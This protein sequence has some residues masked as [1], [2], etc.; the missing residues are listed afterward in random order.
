MALR[1]L[2][3]ILPEGDL[4]KL[5]GVFRTDS[6]RGGPWRY[7]IEGGRKIVRVLI[8]AEESARLV[9]AIEQRCAGTAGSAS[10]T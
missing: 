10:P 2:D 1:L 8:E 4:E 5:K 3:V 6:C 7:P 9:D